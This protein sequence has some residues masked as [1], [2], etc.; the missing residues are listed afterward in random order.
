MKLRP[1]SLVRFVSLAGASTRAAAARVAAARVDV[2]VEL[3]GHTLHS[4]LPVLA[5]RPARVQLS[6]LGHPL[7]SGAP[8]IDYYVSDV[9]AAPPHPAAR[10]FSEAR[11]AFAPDY[12]L[13]G[14]YRDTQRFRSG[15]I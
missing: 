4:G 13:D 8:F 7:S 9:V 15:N 14:S 5:H 10:M 11:G 12:P 3:N 6:F 2:L 1:P